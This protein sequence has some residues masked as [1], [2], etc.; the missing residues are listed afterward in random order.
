M[1]DVPDVD[2]HFEDVVVGTE[3]ETAPHTLTREDILAFADVTRDHH[4]LHVDAEFCRSMGFDAPI[5]H[6]LLGLSLMEGLKSELRLYEHTSIASLGWD[7]VRFR[8]PILAGDTV[9]A[10]VRF[11]DKRDSRKP[12]RGVVTESVSLLNQSGEVVTE[13]VHVTLLKR[14]G[15]SEVPEHST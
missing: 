8:K 13:A 11:T 7:A 5:A 15:S 3:V 14:R 2:L 6:G 10:R 12:D 4:P 1:M 9:H